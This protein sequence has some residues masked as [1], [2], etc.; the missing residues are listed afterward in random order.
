TEQEAIEFAAEQA[1]ALQ[2]EAAGVAEP[3]PPLTPE[4]PAP[5][6]EEVA[7][8]PP[9]TAALEQDAE[10]LLEVAKARD[11]GNPAVLAFEAALEKVKAAT[12]D[13]RREALIELDNAEDAIKSITGEVEAPPPPPPIKP[14]T[15][16]AVR[17][18]VVAKRKRNRTGVPKRSKQDVAAIVSAFATYLNSPTAANASALTEKL[19]TEERSKRIERFTNRLR[20][21]VVNEGLTKSDAIK[22]AADETLKG[23]LPSV[24]PNFLQD[25]TN[26]VRDALMDHVYFVLE[27]ENDLGYELLSTYTA[28]SNAL[29]GKPIPRT[30]GR[31]GGSAF[32]R[33]QRVFGGGAQPLMPALDMVAKQRKPLSDIVRGM[34]HRKPQPQIDVDKEMQ[35]WLSSL[36]VRPAQQQLIIPAQA[37]E[38]SLQR[39]IEGNVPELFEVSDKRTDKQR[40]I[41]ADILRIEL[42]PQP[43][44]VKTKF[45]APIDNAFKQYPL[46]SFGEKQSIVRVLKEAGMTAADV[47]NFLRANK[48]SVDFSFWRQAKLLAS[49]HP[50]AFYNANVQAWKAMW[51]QKEAEAHWKR[52]TADPDYELYEQIHL[53]T[54]ADPLRVPDFASGTKRYRGAE[55][56]GFLTQER[57][58]PRFTSKLWHIKLSSRSFVTGLNE[59]VWRVWK[60]KLALERRYSDKVASG[61]IRLAEGESVDIVKEMAAQQRLLSNMV[62]RGSL[63]T[64]GG[65]VDARGLAPVISAFFFAARSK[66]G[67][68][69]FPVQLLGFANGKFNARV[70]REA[71]KDFALMNSYIIGSLY[72]GQWLGLWT[73]E[74]DPRNAEFLSFRIGNM[75]IDPWAGY[76]QFVVL[77]TRLF[78]GTGVSSVTGAEFLSDPIGSIVR[79]FRS[80]VAPL[81]AILLDF[82]TGRNFIGEA[83]EITNARQWLERIAPFAVWDIYEAFEEGTK[84]GI[85]SIIPAILGEGVQTYTGDWVKDVTMLGLPKYAENA[86]YGIVDPKYTTADFWSDYAS[87]FKG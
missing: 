84:E 66:L 53:D 51:S 61:E 23:E 72:L 28:L 69:F 3:T 57:P 37:L 70:M 48:A 34:Y 49:G 14:K 79:F 19:R 45:D 62:Q 41:A 24:D 20:E 63:T 85:I 47:G 73:V 46:L 64:P 81:P 11:P 50:I 68:F 65:A 60:D 13:A 87:D 10:R 7:A 2:R 83:V 77:Y 9:L 29:A 43:V 59:I 71:W 16:P 31:R 75:R 78:T 58:I 56:F 15:L 40:Q 35:E 86:G 1:N 76:R 54:G 21:L 30:P 18:D 52:I 38:P 12:G 26:E 55:E 67:R 4:V 36:D 8:E 44:G 22:Q 33:L 39:F 27:A 25:V 32:T 5:T 42:A 6:A 80:S 82:W 17:P 74:D